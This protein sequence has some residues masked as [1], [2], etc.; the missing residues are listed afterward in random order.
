MQRSSSC[1]E[2]PL[3]EW[4]QLGKDESAAAPEQAIGFRLLCALVLLIAAWEDQ[5]LRSR[6]WSP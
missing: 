5:P 3:L 6:P 2:V 1:V 4:R